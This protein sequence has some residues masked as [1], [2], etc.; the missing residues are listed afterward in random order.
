V[1]EYCGLPKVSSYPQLNNTIGKEE[2]KAVVSSEILTR[3]TIS[4]AYAFFAFFGS[5]E[6]VEL[7]FV[8]PFYDV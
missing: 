4:L 3:F 2:E 5:L 6:C 1:R 8:S 7:S